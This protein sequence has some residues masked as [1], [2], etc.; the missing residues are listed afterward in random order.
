MSKLYITDHIDHDVM[1]DAEQVSYTPE[2]REIWTREKYVNRRRG[3]PAL[4]LAADGKCIGGIYVEHGFF[5]VSILPKYYG[6]CSFIYLHGLKWA[7]SHAD[8]LYAGI[9]ESN[10]RCMRFA[11]HS[12]WEKIGRYNGVAYFRSNKKFFDRLTKRRRRLVTEDAI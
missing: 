12:G 1:Y 9:M 5:H 8:P 4:G 11:E 3:L 10:E 6:K 7:L 2:I